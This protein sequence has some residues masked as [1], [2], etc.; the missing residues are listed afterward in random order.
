MSGPDPHAPLAP[1][2]V[3]QALAELDGWDGDVNGLQRSW[4][5]AGFPQA[6]AFMAACVEAIEGLG[7]HPEWRN[8]YD[9]VWVVLRTHDAGN[10]VTLRDLELAR[11]LQRRASEHG[12]A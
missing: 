8:V 12:A 7:H 4:R 10:R 6:V 3:G 5:F 9:R 2:L 1:A 11:L